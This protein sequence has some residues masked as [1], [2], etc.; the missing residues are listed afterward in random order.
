MDFENNV[1]KRLSQP[2]GNE[3][4]GSE[5]RELNDLKAELQGT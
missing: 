2:K 4:I 1:L 5:I 3:V